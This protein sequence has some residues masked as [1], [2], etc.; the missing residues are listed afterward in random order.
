MHPAIFLDRDGVIIEN[1]PT[2]VRTWDEVFFFPQALA[3]LAVLRESPYRIV[4]VTNQSAVGRGLISLE[5]ADEIN[6]R[7]IAEIE[8]NNGRIDA[9]LTCPHSPEDQCACRKPQ[10]GLLHQAAKQLS[11][12][13]S[14]S[15]MIGDSLSD[16]A[17][18]QAAGVRK[19]I[20]VLTGR[21]ADQLTMPEAK[22]LQPFSVYPSLQA[23]VLSELSTP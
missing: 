2:Y 17:A 15:F 4:I 18:G 7:V 16:V 19:S 13:L 10:P 5:M 8:K 11:I 20:L 12:D 3:A 14:R 23:A 9:V 6:Q 22:T 1:V 21:G